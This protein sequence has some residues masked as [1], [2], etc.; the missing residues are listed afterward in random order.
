MLAARKFTQAAKDDVGDKS[1]FEYLALPTDEER[2][3]WDLRAA[4]REGA[5]VGWSGGDDDNAAGGESE[6]AGGSRSSGARQQQQ[7]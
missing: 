3:M 4:R 1:V 7:Q 6:G 5:L 2:A